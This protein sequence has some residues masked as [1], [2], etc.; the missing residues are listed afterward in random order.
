MQ[1]GEN[2]RWHD[3]SDI[4]SYTEQIAPRVVEDDK[5]L[6]QEIETLKTR[7]LAMEGKLNDNLTKIEQLENLLAAGLLVVQRSA[8]LENNVAKE[9]KPSLSAKQIEER[10]RQQREQDAQKLVE[11]FQ[12]ETADT[13]WAA[14]T[15][16]LLDERFLSNKA[17][18]DAELLHSE[19]RTTLCR[20]EVRLINSEQL[21]P[22][23]DW[24]PILAGNELPRLS[25][26]SDEQPDGSV[27]VTAYLARQRHRFP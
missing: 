11:Q 16:A 22:F 14:T 6:R 27:L 5:V 24:L 1:Y 2:K 12:S 19:C 8:A 4:T 20:I 13:E 15:N 21:I 7:M 26:F 17:F 18:P 9:K 3:F 10:N 25:L 23:G